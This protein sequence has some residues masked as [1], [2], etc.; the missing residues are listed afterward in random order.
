[1]YK[2]LTV[3]L[4]LSFIFGETN[5]IDQTNLKTAD[6]KK[7]KTE[8]N[9]DVDVSVLSRKAIETSKSPKAASKRENVTERTRALHG[10]LCTA[11]YPAACRVHVVKSH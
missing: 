10:R 7:E 4:A 9:S 6:I 5:L 11:P 1:M 2:M 3:C 8:N